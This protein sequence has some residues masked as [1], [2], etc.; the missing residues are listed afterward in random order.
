VRLQGR[1]ADTLLSLFNSS[2]QKYML[3]PSDENFK[4]E[5]DFIPFTLIMYN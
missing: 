3:K 5:L 1:S 4:N 2:Y